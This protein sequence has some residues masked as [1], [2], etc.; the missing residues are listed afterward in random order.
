MNGRRI[1]IALIGLLLALG[2]AAPAQAAVV[3]VTSAGTITGSA[4]VGQKLTAERRGLHG[5]DRHDHGTDVAA[6]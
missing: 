1:Y 4:V 3:D 6:V 5:P 2:V